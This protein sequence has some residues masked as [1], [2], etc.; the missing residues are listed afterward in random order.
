[1]PHQYNTG[2]ANQTNYN[3]IIINR[4]EQYKIAFY[5]LT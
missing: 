3:S 5:K 2:I 1:M 4:T